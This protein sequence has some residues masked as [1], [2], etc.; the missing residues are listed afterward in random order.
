MNNDIRATERDPKTGE[1][2]TVKEG[3]ALAYVVGWLESK[4]K[5]HDLVMKYQGGAFVYG[6]FQGFIFR[7]LGEIYGV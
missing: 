5:Q 6:Y 2:I 4:Y 1:R 7:K 3:P